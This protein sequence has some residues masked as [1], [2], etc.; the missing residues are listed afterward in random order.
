MSDQPAGE[1]VKGYAFESQEAADALRDALWSVQ[2]ID[3]SVAILTV[4]PGHN[5]V[6][7]ELDPAL[8]AGLTAIQKV[9]L[10]NGG[11]PAFGG[12]VTGDT[13]KIFTD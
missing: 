12:V 7:F 1:H 13:V 6:V 10:A 9:V 8:T 4:T 3:R 2:H 5:H 11:S